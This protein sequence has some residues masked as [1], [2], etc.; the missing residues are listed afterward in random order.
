VK[1]SEIDKKLDPKY[2]KKVREEKAAKNLSRT[3]FKIKVK[4][5][6]RIDD[7]R[8][9]VCKYRGRTVF[10]KDGEDWIGIQVEH[11]EGIHN[12]TVKGKKYF[13]CAPGKG[14]MVRPQ[15]IVEDLGLP[16]GK[17]LNKKIIK[18]S[19]Q[20]RA[21]LQDIAF[22]KEEEYQRRLREKKEKKKKHKKQEYTIYDDWQPPKFDDLEEDHGDAFQAKLLHSPNKFKQDVKAEKKLMMYEI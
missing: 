1:Q 4:R 16:D 20:I 8:I 3:G 15:R 18:G 6:Y 21:L 7:G 10:G 12:G 2:R 13:I 5:R 22:E 9:G 11:G 17:E 19:K 14:I